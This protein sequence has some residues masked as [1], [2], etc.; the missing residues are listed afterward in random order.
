MREKYIKTSDHV[1]KDFLFTYMEIN[2]Y[3]K[4]LII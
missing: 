4:R 3:I 2:F 1:I